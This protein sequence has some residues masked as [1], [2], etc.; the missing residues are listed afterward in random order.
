MVAAMEQMSRVTAMDQTITL[1]QV[2][3]SSEQLPVSDQLKLISLLAQRLCGHMTN[4][5]KPVD[6]LSTLGLGAEL[7]QEIDSD[8]YIEQE[9]DSWED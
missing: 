1:D 7:W 3:E 5:A 2:L 9:R 6:M 8:A 4:E